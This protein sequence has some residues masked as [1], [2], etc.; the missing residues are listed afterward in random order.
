MIGAHIKSEGGE[1]WKKLIGIY[2]IYYKS[3]VGYR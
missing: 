3:M 2:W 1:L